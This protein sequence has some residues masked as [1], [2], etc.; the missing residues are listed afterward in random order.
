LH[1]AV[2]QT[3]GAHAFCTT[4]QLPPPSQVDTS[5]STLPPQLGVPHT[6]VVFAKLHAVAFVPSQLYPHAG[7][8]VVVLHAPWPTRGCPTTV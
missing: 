7:S 8:P 5:V 4:L 6:V 3:Y 1:D 2:P